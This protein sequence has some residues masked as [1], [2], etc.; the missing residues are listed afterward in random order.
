MKIVTKR[1]YVLL[2]HKV[3]FP[4][5]ALLDNS[6]EI[7]A[8][9]VITPIA[10]GCNYSTEVRAESLAAERALDALKLRGI[11]KVD[12]LHDLMEWLYRHPEAFSSLFREG[13]EVDPLIQKRTRRHDLLFQKGRLK[14]HL[15]NARK[16]NPTLKWVGEAF[17]KGNLLCRKAASPG[18][19]GLVIGQVSPC[20]AY[21]CSTTV[22]VIKEA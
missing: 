13:R 6:G 17:F 18:G 8:K 7:I 21:P 9:V 14:K 2:D 22:R 10:P 12:V 1:D 4:V 19:K 15:E 11:A 3:W 16:Y 20:G 5:G